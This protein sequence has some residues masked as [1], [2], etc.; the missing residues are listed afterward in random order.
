MFVLLFGSR[1][2]S[3]SWAGRIWVRTH[4]TCGFNAGDKTWKSEEKAADKRAKCG[5]TNK[6]NF[7]NAGVEKFSSTVVV[8]CHAACK[9]IGKRPHETKHKPAK[10]LK[11]NFRM[12][13]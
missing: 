10:P 11:T 1:C 7:Q 12:L 3:T 2:I 8:P 9:S 13:V 6:N 4:A 5:E